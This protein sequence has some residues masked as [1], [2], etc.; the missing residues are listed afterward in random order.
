[1]EKVELCTH[2]D[3][4]TTVLD[5]LHDTIIRRVVVMRDTNKLITE[6]SEVIIRNKAGKKEKS[7]MSTSD[8]LVKIKEELNKSDS[9]KHN[10]SIWVILVI[11]V[12]IVFNFFARRGRS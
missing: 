5:T 9:K 6:L 10:R 11:L 1:M 8:S 12:L 7:L 4:K 3:T 2:T